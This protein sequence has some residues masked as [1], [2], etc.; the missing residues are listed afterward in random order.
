MAS[1]PS[2]AY[3]YGWPVAGFVAGP[4]VDGPKPDQTGIVGVIVW[5]RSTYFASMSALS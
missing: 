2:A 3:V 5:V 4:N 1:K